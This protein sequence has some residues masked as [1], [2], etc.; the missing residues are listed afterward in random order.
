MQVLSELSPFQRERGAGQMLQPGYIRS[1][2]DI[3]QVCGLLSCSH[4]FNPLYT[5]SPANL[6]DTCSCGCMHCG[7]PHA[8]LHHLWQ[9]REGTRVSMRLKLTCCLSMQQCEDLE[10]GESLRHLYHIIR[11]AIMLNDA[12]LLD[13]LLAEE[14]VMDVVSPPTVM[15]YFILGASSSSAHIACRYVWGL[16]LLC[17][18]CIACVWVCVCACN[19]ACRSW[20]DKVG[21]VGLLATNC[22]R[23]SHGS[24]MNGLLG[25]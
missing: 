19:E 17:P 25:S 3:F 1:L 6:S 8:S 22:L 5:W 13:L 7:W 11:G 4:I 2:L 12:N 14:N 15:L 21:S 10:D 18:S 24:A 23:L 20:L 16:T 9:P